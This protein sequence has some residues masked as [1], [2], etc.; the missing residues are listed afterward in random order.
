MVTPEETQQLIALAVQASAKSF[1]FRSR[2]KIGAAVLTTDNKYF[3]GCIIESV[4]FGLGTCAERSAINHAVVHGKYEYKAVAIVDETP[5]LPCG[6]CL[7]Y[8]MQFY[9]INNLD[10]TIIIADTKGKVLETHTL[11]ELL[12]HGF[13]SRHAEDLRQ[14]KNRS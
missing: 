14:Y 1:V 3:E 8:L 6:V 5:T 9:Q 10:I 2:R 11:L 4:I 7:Q 13:L 12:P